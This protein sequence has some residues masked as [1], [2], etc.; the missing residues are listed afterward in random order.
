MARSSVGQLILKVTSL[1]NE[2]LLLNTAVYD[3][4]LS[5]G[6]VREYSANVITQNIY[7]QVDRN[8]YSSSTVQCIVDYYRDDTTV[9]KQ[10]K[11]VRT[12]SGQRRLRKTTAGWKL[13]V[14]YR[15][16]REKWAPLR[17]LKE[18][19]PIEVTEFALFSFVGG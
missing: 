19:C 11:Y 5:D 1:V 12:R 10:N 17:I 14:R 16:G 3:V 6:V 15:D 2:N 13:L 8:S 4:E 9:L 7:Q 18:S